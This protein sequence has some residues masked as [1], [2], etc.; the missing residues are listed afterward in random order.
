[1]KYKERKDFGRAQT[2]EV[3]GKRMLTRLPGLRLG[4]IVPRM[5]GISSTRQP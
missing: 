3:E 4:G 5:H 2:E 1:M